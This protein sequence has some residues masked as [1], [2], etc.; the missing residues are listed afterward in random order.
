[1]YVRVTLFVVH[2]SPSS[3]TATGTAAACAT[4]AAREGRR[5]HPH[6]SKSAH[7]GSIVHIVPVASGA[8]GGVHWTAL[9]DTSVAGTVVVPNRHCS[10]GV[11]TK[12]P[13][14]TVI[15]VGAAASTNV[16]LIECTE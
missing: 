5:S 8:T 10:C 13:P 14:V 12:Y 15:A 6:G 7:V 9:L 4:H 16:G 11:L 1:M 2:C 3:D